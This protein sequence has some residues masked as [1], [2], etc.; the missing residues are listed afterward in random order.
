MSR[1]PVA[2]PPKPLNAELY[3]PAQVLASQG[4]L[5]ADHAAWTLN[6]RDEARY[7]AGLTVRLLPEFHPPAREVSDRV[8]AGSCGCGAEWRGELACHC[9]TC[10]LTF[11]SVGG[12]DEHR[13]GGRCRTEAELTKRG[14]EPNADGLW[15]HPR[16]GNSIPGRLP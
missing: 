13:V 11:R 15:R 7:V 4:L 16:P 12:F 3:S 1:R 8:V 5:P 10:H 6:E 9:A 14:L 2:P